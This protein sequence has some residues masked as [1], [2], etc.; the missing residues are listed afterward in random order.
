MKVCAC[1]RLYVRKCTCVHVFAYMYASARVCMCL[2]MCTRV[3]VCTTHT[4]TV[5]QFIVSSFVCFHSHFQLGMVYTLSKSFDQSVEV[6]CVVRVNY[7][8]T[9]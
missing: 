6:S 8:C 4:R 2:F 7:F 9:K 5:D 1:V 3:H